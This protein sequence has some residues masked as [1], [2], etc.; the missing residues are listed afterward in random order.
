MFDLSLHEHPNRYEL[1]AK[2]IALSIVTL[3]SGYTIS[4]RHLELA[5][6]SQL[7]C[8]RWGHRIIALIEALP[9]IG[10]L[11]VLIEKVIYLFEESKFLS[12]NT[13]LNL[14]LTSCNNLSYELY[15]THHIVPLAP[16]ITTIDTGIKKMWRNSLKAIGEHIKRFN[17]EAYHLPKDALPSV[18]E[19]FRGKI[20]SLDF[21]TASAESIGRRPTMEDAILYKCLD[22]GLICGIFDGHG[23]EEVAHIAKNIYEQ[24]FEAILVENAYDVRK[25]FIA[26]AK[27]IEEEVISNPQLRFIGSTAVVI[28][29]DQKTNLIYTS[30]IGDSLAK[31]YR[32]NQRQFKTLPLSPIRDW[33]SSKDAMR[34]ATAYQNYS[35]YQK[36]K[37][38]PNPKELR[39]PINI[40]VNVSRAFGD[41]FVKNCFNSPT[42]VSK[43]KISINRLFVDDYIMLA[44]D[45]VSDYVSD[46]ELNVIFQ[47]FHEQFH[48]HWISPLE[49]LCQNIVEFSIKTKR[50]DD[51]VSVLVVK[52]NCLL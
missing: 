17:R 13:K 39:V 50:S 22:R 9:I 44:C 19:L 25:T 37:N 16:T 29:I 32:S 12:T 35:I 42:I 7:S 20:E 6:N 18:D 30:T 33:S 48:D 26:I 34:V 21:I 2:E 40:G 1:D 15:S 27:K 14:P 38:H 3:G 43:P 52:A 5:A 24:Y 51:N 46:E 45:G 4:K 11:S 23:G 47:Q 41:L 49:E 28:Y 10:M 8:E 31:I 36:W